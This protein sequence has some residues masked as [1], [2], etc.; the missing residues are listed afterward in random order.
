M[1]QKIK[2]KL[3]KLICS[4]LTIQ[5][6]DIKEWDTQAETEDKRKKWILSALV[7]ERSGFR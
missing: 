2:S 3:E 5:R 6:D 1:R 7:T 4:I